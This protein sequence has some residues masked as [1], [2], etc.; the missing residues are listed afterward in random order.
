MG[1]GALFAR[2]LQELWRPF[3]SPVHSGHVRGF[4]HG[5]VH[6]RQLH[7]LHP[8]GTD[9]ASR[10]LVCV[11]LSQMHF[12]FHTDVFVISGSLDEWNR[13]AADEWRHYLWEMRN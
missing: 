8:D 12:Q 10:I 5:G 6:D 11:F 2:R 1:R 3:R 13:C 9:A 4:D 7:V